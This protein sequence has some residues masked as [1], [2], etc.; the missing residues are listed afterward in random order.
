MVAR[1]KIVAGGKT[2]PEIIQRNFIIVIINGSIIDTV[3]IFGVSRPLIPVSIKKMFRGKFCFG[4]EMIIRKIKDC[5]LTMLV[6]AFQAV[7][8]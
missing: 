5:F 3:G 2:G 4:I 6:T 8:I 7:K 1:I